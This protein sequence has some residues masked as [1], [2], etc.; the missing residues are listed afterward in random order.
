MKLRLRRALWPDCSEAMHACEMAAYAASSSTRAV[1]VLAR[2]NGRLGGFVEVSERD[3]VDG[4]MSPRVAYL[5]GWFVEPDSGVM[6]S[7]AAW[8]QPPN[9]GALR[10]A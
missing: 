5:E 2:E 9:V 3:R 7:A 8:W 1:F 4:S 10:A 6:A